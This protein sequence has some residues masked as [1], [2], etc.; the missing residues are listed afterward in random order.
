MRTG[1]TV[2]VSERSKL[3]TFSHS[4]DPSVW[5]GR[6]LGGPLVAAS[7]PGSLALSQDR[8]VVG[9][10]EGPGSFLTISGVSEPRP[11]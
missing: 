5:E 11:V 9:A 3:L 6:E 10:G 1:D 8:R 2:W 7:R 4:W